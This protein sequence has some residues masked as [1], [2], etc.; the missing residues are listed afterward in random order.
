[1][2]AVPPTQ[3][4]MIPGAHSGWQAVTATVKGAAEGFDTADV[5]ALLTIARHL[6]PSPE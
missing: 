4:Q 6:D 1:M 5:L 2:P 3:P